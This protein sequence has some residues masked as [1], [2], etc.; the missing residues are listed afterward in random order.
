ME[1]IFGRI[2]HHPFG[3]APRFSTTELCCSAPG[4]LLRF[5]SV[6]E[7]NNFA[8]NEEQKNNRNP[9]TQ[10]M[11]ILRDEYPIW[12]QID[13]YIFGDNISLHTVSS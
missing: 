6:V 11:R 4:N 12:Y 1:V 3:P 8:K 2:S 7:N 10:W 9:Y 5:A 13:I